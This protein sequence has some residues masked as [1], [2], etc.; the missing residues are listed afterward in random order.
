MITVKP[1]Y[2]LEKNK[3]FLELYD[4][5]YNE[6]DNFEEESSRISSIPVKN[7]QDHI[8]QEREINA[9]YNNITENHLVFE[10]ELI[11][12]EKYEYIY[13]PSKDNISKKLVINKG[14]GKDS[15]DRESIAL[16]DIC[17]KID[18]YVVFNSFKNENFEN[19]LNT[20]NNINQKDKI[21][22][23][24][25]IVDNPYN[26]NSIYDLKTI[27]KNIKNFRK[28]LN[29]KYNIDLD[30]DLEYDRDLNLFNEVLG[31]YNSALKIDL[32]VYSIPIIL[33][34]V[35]IHMKRGELAYINTGYIDYFNEQEKEIADKTGKIQ[36]YIMLYDFLHRKLFSKLTLE[37]KYEDLIALKDLANSFF[38][39]G[40]FFRASKIYQN[41]N[42]RFNFGDVFG[43]IFEENEVPIREKNPIVYNMLNEIRI[44]CHNNLASAKL[45]LGK[46]YSAF[47]TA[48]KVNSFFDL[49]NLK[50]KFYKIWKGCIYV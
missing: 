10:C 28:E 14:F 37:E 48:D 35:L 18:N 12:I 20:L 45:K 24:N 8:I 47:S 1:S 44:S 7:N 19:N 29:S 46:W 5:K 3:E 2:M 33:R 34:K 32:R 27:Q 42:Y 23:I 39:N 6:P 40:K 43:M 41:I 36:I 38:K 16:I 30:M 15:P 9:L 4:I 50:N 25:D 13:K 21:I 49:L 31:N 26:F 17:I 22:D 11:N